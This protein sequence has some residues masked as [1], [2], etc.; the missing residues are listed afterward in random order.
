MDAAARVKA[1]PV[2]LHVKLA[3]NADNQDMTRIGNVTDNNLARIEE[4]KR[5]RAFLLGP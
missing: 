4:Y 2:A 3:D 1:N 5:V